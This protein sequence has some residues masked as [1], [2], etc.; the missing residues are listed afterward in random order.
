VPVT[1][2][3]GARRE[4]GSRAHHAIGRQ[5]DAVR[6][7]GAVQTALLVAIGLVLLMLVVLIVRGLV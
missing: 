2:E 3:A 4:A 7:A 6:A 1:P 5:T